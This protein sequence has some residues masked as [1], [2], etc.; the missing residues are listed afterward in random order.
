MERLSTH[1]PEVRKATLLWFIHGVLT[2]RGVVSDSTIVDVI[3]K[4]IKELMKYEKT[5]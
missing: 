3:S 5:S 4:E 2:T 1:T